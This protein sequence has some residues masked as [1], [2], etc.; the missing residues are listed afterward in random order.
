MS[1]KY[2]TPTA[3]R[4][5][6]E[7]RLNNFSKKHGV[8]LHKLRRQVAFDRLLCRLFKSH[9]GNLFLKGGYSMELRIQ[10][11]RTTKDIDLVLRAK[12]LAKRE[13]QDLEIFDLLQ[14]A[15]R[16]DLNDF[17]VFLVGNPTLDL[18]AVPYGGSRFPIEA[19]LDGRLFIRF[20]MDV[21]VSSLVLD[22]VEEI[23]SQDWLE[24]AGIE[25]L[26]FPAISREQQFAE[27]LHAYTLPREESENS[28]VKDLIDL[29]LLIGTK[30]LKTDVLRT[31]IGKIFEYR[32][33]H[34]IPKAISPP[35]ANWESKFGKIAKECGLDGD[36]AKT[37]AQVEA[38][39]GGLPR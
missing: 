11:A 7:G 9:P 20:P 17:F 3:F 24:F 13:A 25:T 15:A 35:P 28:R 19:H 33:T 1:R 32:G 38:F 27:K 39:I 30:T 29:A 8:D 12:T 2:G 4:T 37:F 26:P 10:K 6:L 5:A 22:P 14:K 31:A 21:V 23:G 16:E 18:E 34:G 36:I